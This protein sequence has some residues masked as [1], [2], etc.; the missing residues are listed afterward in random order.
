MAKYDA[1]LYLTLNNYGYSDQSL[2]NVKAYLLHQTMPKSMDTAQKV[3]RFK[4]K[5]HDKWEVLI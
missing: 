3:R 1:S 4:Q 5:W 2:A